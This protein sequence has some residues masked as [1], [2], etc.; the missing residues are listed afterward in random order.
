MGRLAASFYTI[1]FF[2]GAIPAL[3]YV[4][5]I[6]F[7]LAYLTSGDLEFSPHTVFA[8]I[9]IIKFSVYLKVLF[10]LFIHNPSHYLTGVTAEE[11]KEFPGSYI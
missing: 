9:K 3:Y 10:G 6:G 4:G 11:S 1:L 2:S 8:F 7:G 5:L